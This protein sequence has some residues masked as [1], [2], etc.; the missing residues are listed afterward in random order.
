MLPVKR[1]RG[2]GAGAGRLLLCVACV[3]T[4]EARTGMEPADTPAGHPPAAGMEDGTGGWCAQEP[5]PPSA[6]K[7]RS[8]AGPKASPWGRPVSAA[9]SASEAASSK[10]APPNTPSRRGA[11]DLRE[12]T[13]L[14][15]P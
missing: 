11:D 6:P 14:V 4:S 2:S 10:L 12:L 15:R 8:D 3:N 1:P 5:P 9:S 7:E 13:L